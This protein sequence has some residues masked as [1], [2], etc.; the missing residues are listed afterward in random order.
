MANK[1]AQGIY[2]VKNADKYVGKGSVKYR[3]N[4]E[5][6]FMRW[7]D[8]HPGVL[9]WASESIR[10]PYRHPITGKN[11]SYVPDFFVQYVDKNNKVHTEVIEIK[12]QK[13]QLME[14]AGRSKYNQAQVII[15][16]AKWQACTAFCKSN[17]MVFRVLNE[18]DLFVN[19][20][21]K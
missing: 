4:W 13:H 20:K 1:W 21:A 6:Q 3:S 15:N 19:G 14:K 5:F 9:K 12:P 8:T 16:Q 11:T 17:G 10:I 18:N 2:Q 7:C